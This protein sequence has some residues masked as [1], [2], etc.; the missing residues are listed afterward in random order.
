MFFEEEKKKNRLTLM[1]EM[2]FADTAEDQRDALDRLLP[3]Q[4]ADFIDLFEIMPGPT[5]VHSPVRPALAT[6]SCR[7]RAKGMRFLADALDKPL[8]EITRRAE[9]L[10]EFNPMLGMR[11]GAHWGS[12]F[13]RSTKC[14]PARFSRPRLK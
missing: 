8:S 13:P 1:R 6:N 3:M 9:A 4:R 10:A 2:I 14:R 5:C 12:P 7:I 11:R